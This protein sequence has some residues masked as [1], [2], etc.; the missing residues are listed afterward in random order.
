M[1]K[2]KGE[3]GGEEAGRDLHPGMGELKQRRDPRIWGNPVSNGEIDWDRREAFETVGIGWSGWSVTD[4]TEWQ[5]HRWSVLWPKVPRTGTCFTGVQGGWEVER[6]D[7]KTDLERELLLAV[8]RWTE[9][10]NPQQGM[11]T[12]K[13]GLP[14][15]QGAIAESCRGRSHYCNLSL[16]THQH[17]LPSNLKSPLRAGPHLPYAG[18]QKRP[19]LGPYLLHLWLPA[20]LWIWCCRGSWDPN[21]HTASAP[22]PNWGRTKSSKAATGPDSCGWNTCRGGDKTKLN[23]RDGVSKEEDWKSFHQLYKMQIKCQQS[24]R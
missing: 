22:C 17:W 2:K 8:G 1:E 4:W 11:P 20:S 24:A 3:R 15:K 19:S 5:I 7:W 18:H 12:R 9:G 13:T 10:G 16:P 6:G 21:S 14:W 23:P